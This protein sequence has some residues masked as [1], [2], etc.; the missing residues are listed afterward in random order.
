MTHPE[1]PVSS[2]IP[3][4]YAPVPD[5]QVRDDRH[6][7]RV[8]SASYRVVGGLEVFGCVMGSLSVQ[9]YRVLWMSS[10]GLFWML[11]GVY[12]ALRSLRHMSMVIAGVSCVPIPLGTIMGSFT[13][14]VLS[15]PGVKLLC[16][17]RE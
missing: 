3:L 10:V 6:A 2:P 4:T 16:R 14:A 8:L 7:L 9:N 11:S 1:G 12:I 15:R 17:N 5:S 13:L